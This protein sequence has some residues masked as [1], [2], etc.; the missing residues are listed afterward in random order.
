[1]G[2]I[3]RRTK[4]QPIVIL[5]G[6]GI[7]REILGPKW[8]CSPLASWEELLRET[9]R[10]ARIPLGLFGGN[11]LTAT[12]ETMVLEG[13]ANGFRDDQQTQI[14]P[15]RC[16]AAE[17]DL[18]LRR[19]CS[20]VIGDHSADL[21]RY[22]MN[23]WVPQCLS[24]LCQSRQ[25]HL[26]DF[27]FDT[28]IG[29]SVGMVSD[30]PAPVGKPLSSSGLTMEEHAALRRSWPLLGP[31]SSRVWKPHGWFLRPKT[32]RLGVRD[33]GLEGAGYRRAFGHHKAVERVHGTNKSIQ[34]ETWVAVCFVT[35][36]EPSVLGSGVMSGASIGCWFSAHA[37]EQ[38]RSRSGRSLLSLGSVDRCQ[39]GWAIPDTP[40][41]KPQSV[42]RSQMTKPS[43][44]ID[45]KRCARRVSRHRG[46][47]P[48]SIEKRGHDE[49][50]LVKS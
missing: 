35:S 11:S 49:W 34:T 41:G 21:A 12:W 15:F 36:A 22:Y 31:H 43:E 42:Q 20:Q 37:I 25:V 47:D 13:M 48:Y 27:N 33:F 28:L 23:H 8:Q 24:M 45:G 1:M 44:S 50:R 2:T 14:R 40:V 38:E 29:E 5:L 7:H 32:L 17:V 6:S 19:V 46:L 18:A 26:V 3:R 4:Q 30:S 10:R 16:A 9:A 39:S